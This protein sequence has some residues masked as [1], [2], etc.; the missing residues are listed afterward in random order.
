MISKINA[1]AFCESIIGKYK[2][3]ERHIDYLIGN[4]IIKFFFYFKSTDPFCNATVIDDLNTALRKYDLNVMCDFYMK[5]DIVRHSDKYDMCW[6]FFSY[7]SIGTYH[8][9][10][11]IRT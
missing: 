7:N 4:E 10:R 3:E 1:I 9:E 2:T 11:H 8:V 5:L 6:T